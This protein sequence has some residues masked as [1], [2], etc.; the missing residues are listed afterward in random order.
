[1]IKFLKD[2]G[3]NKKGDECDHLH[4]D[5][6]IRVGVAEKVEVKEVKVEKAKQKETKKRE[7]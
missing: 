7:V 5:Y 1:M 6:L 3:N 4:E 2:H